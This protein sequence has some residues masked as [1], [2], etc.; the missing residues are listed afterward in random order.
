ME[1]R[2]LE[3]LGI[4]TS[5]LGFGAMRLPLTPEGKI[6]ELLAESMIDK[7]I[8]AGVNYIDTAYPYHNRESEPFVGRVL[9]KFEKDSYYLATKLPLF[10]INS[11]DD[12]T[13]IFEEQLQVLD[14][15]YIDFYLFHGLSGKT[16]DKMV[17]LG[18]VEYLEEMKAQGKIKYLGFSFHF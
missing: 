8:A 7:A 3:N 18:V 11:L 9:N 16:L 13:R 4:T 14:K 5:L 1:K 2:Y 17:S 6:D 15:E 10:I 12:A